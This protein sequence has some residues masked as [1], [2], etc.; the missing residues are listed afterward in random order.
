MNSKIEERHRALLFRYS[1]AARL[2]VFLLLHL[3]SA[4]LPLFDASPLLVQGINKLEFPLLRWDMFHFHHIAAHGYVYE[5]EWAF[6]GVPY[7]MRYLALLQPSNKH[8]ATNLLLMGMTAAIACESSQ[9]LY[10][11]SLYHLRSAHLAFLTSILS[12]IP[13]SPV[14]AYFAPYNEPFFTHF[15]YRG[16]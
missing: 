7:L 1:V 13:T 8:G 14:I 12:L 10:S 6:F 9:L 4:W 3:A 11:L 5:H 15:S 2:F 16:R